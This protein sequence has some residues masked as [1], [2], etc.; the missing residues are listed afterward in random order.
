MEFPYEPKS[1][2][3]DRCGIG[4]RVGNLCRLPQGEA[5]RR[6]VDLSYCAVEPR[7]GLLPAVAGRQ[8][9]ASVRFSRQG[10]FTELLGYLVWSMQNRN[11]LVRR[12]AERI[13]RTGL[14]N[15]WR[16]YG[17]CQCARYRQV[18][19]GY[20]RELPD[21]DREGICWR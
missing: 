16:G 11:A 12:S 21:S 15:C 17:R 8:D 13:R 7:P 3:T 5:L 20:G 6:I 19:Q 4:G 18:R 14:A 10:G 9:H 2:G 1:A